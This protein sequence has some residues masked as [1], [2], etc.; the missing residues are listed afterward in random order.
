MVRLEQVAVD[1]NI[2]QN[3]R[4]PNGISL[5]INQENQI[6]K[7]F[8]IITIYIIFGLGLIA[9]LILNLIGT[10]FITEYIFTDKTLDK[11]QNWQIN[12]M[13]MSIILYWIMIATNIINSCK[14]FFKKDN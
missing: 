10:G 8:A 7:A 13:Q 14:N 3:I 2:N 6:C 1:N 12:L 9:L 5:T 4:I 11:Y